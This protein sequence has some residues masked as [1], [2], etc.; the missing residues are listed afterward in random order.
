MSETTTVTKGRWYPA[1]PPA[2]DGESD[3][4]YTDRL[5]G[6]DGTN[7]SPYDHPRNRQCSIG[8][9]TE[10]TDP[11]S[12]RCK[13]PCHYD[14]YTLKD[15]EGWEA[16]A[17][18]LANCYDLPLQSAFAVILAVVAAGIPRDA[19]SVCKALTTRYQSEISDG[20]VTDVVNILKGSS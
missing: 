8:W 16:Q 5:T 11:Q 1:P 20:F 18:A 13:C 9:H 7:R 17:E 6:A 19:E 3:E 14:G 10:C 12:A 15:A 4:A 2:L